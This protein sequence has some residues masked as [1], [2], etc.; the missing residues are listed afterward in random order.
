MKK[1]LSFCFII[2]CTLTLSSCGLL[3]YLE[4]TNNPESNSAISVEVSSDDKLEVSNISYYSYYNHEN[5]STSVKLDSNNL[6]YYFEPLKD[7]HF[8]NVKVGEDSNGEQINIYLVFK[9]ENIELVR[10]L[11]VKMDF[12]NV[13]PFTQAVEKGYIKLPEIANDDYYL[14][15]EGVIIAKECVK[16]DGTIIINAS[17]SWGECFNYMNPSVYY[18]EDPEG[19][20]V[21]YDEMSNTLNDF[22][23][24]L[25]N[26]DTEKLFYSIHIDVN[27]K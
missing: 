27:A 2:I 13:E 8:G 25:N 23:N 4:N 24:I 7:D 1:L 16:E 3:K 20:K 22:K 15:K 19:I 21:E 6:N 9:I 12:S 18:D 17:F 14:I 11:K 10:D 26:E 5:K